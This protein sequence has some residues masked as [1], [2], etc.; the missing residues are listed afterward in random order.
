MLTYYSPASHFSKIIDLTLSDDEDTRPGSA[1]TGNLG[2]RALP[3]RPSPAAARR[4]VDAPHSNHGLLLEGTFRSLSRH[5]LHSTNSRASCG[6]SG[7]GSAS[8]A[9]LKQSKEQN[10]SSWPDRAYSPKRRRVD[11]SGNSRSGS[12]SSLPIP[13]KQPEVKGVQEPT[14]ADAL[15]LKR[16]L[17]RNHQ[18]LAEA[19]PASLPS[20]SSKMSSEDSAKT[21]S[22][23]LVIVLRQQVFPHINKCLN[24]Y[25]RSIDNL[26]RKQLGKKVCHFAPR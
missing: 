7:Q 12:A 14:A 16:M 21:V 23:G 3:S 18:S 1:I 4:I 25:R 8:A 22:E 20:E 13:G 9:R 11:R 10:Q 19:A 2:C 15:S 5:G 24:S 6:S 26:T 17:L